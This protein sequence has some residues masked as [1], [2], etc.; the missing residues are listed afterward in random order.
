M[1]FFFC[2]SSCV[3]ALLG[4]QVILTDL[5]DRLRLLKK[6]VEA[7]LR[8]GYV[9]GSATVMELLWG[10]DP[11][12]ELIEQKPDYGNQPPLNLPYWKQIH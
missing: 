7:N 3:A 6:N 8:H 10:D 1:L 12:R 9:R 4:G 11:D 2:F 5:P